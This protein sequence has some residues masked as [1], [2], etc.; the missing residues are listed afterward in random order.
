MNNYGRGYVPR[1][2]HEMKIVVLDEQAKSS[3]E[4]KK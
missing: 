1:C 2:D 3:I 4:P